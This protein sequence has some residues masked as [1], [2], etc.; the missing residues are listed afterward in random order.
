M[1]RQ[2]LLQTSLHQTRFITQ[3]CDGRARQA[4]LGQI[5]TVASQQYRALQ[6]QRQT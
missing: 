5:G 6:A 2:E 1:A 3:A 4:V